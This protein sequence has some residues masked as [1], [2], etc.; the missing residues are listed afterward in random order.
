MKKIIALALALVLSLSMAT[1]AFAAGTVDVPGAFSD[2]SDNA[3]LEGSVIWTLPGSEYKL[4]IKDF[5]TDRAGKDTATFTDNHRA[6][7]TD[8]YFAIS[9]VEYETGKEFVESIKFNNDG[10]L[11]I[12][13][14]QDYA[15]TKPV[16]PN[17]KIKN[18]TLTVKKDANDDIKKSD[19]FTLIDPDNRSVGIKLG[20]GVEEI[21]IEDD[22]SPVVEGKE[23]TKFVKGLAGETYGVASF[24][25]FNGDIEVEGRVYKD[26][27]FNFSTDV[28]PNLDIVKANPDADIQFYAFSAAPKFASNME[29][30]LSADEDL[31]IYELKD[32]KLVKSSLK[33]DE[34]SYAYVGKKSTLGT[35]VVSDIELKDA[36]AATDD[37]KNPNTGAN[38]FVG[39]A[40]AL[41]VVSLVAAGAVSIK[42]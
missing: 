8:K 3:V 9:K 34:D 19:K 39:V 28:A 4:D 12:K 6:Y 10:K 41:A 1:V 16:L 35:F 26:E 13:F 31:F 40:V 25:F 27:K 20:Y 32:G 2:A 36:V 30:S 18:I 23:I 22:F 24:S 29:V 38:D 7:F 21:K 37:T 11:V 14:K 15:Q 42:K 33:W 5:E 17:V